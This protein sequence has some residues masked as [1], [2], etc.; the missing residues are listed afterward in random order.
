MILQP[1]MFPIIVMPTH[2]P[3]LKVP[4]VRC[5]LFTRPNQVTL[6]AQDM[7]QS[8]N[9]RGRNLAVSL[10]DRMRSGIVF[11]RPISVALSSLGG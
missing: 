4:L 3:L 5:K 9:H 6:G 1:M 8:T 11:Q 7:R 10:R 2:S